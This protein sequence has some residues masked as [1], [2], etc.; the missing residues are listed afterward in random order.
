[1]KSFQFRIA[2]VAFGA[3]AVLAACHGGSLPFA[4][5]SQSG[6]VQY[7]LAPKNL[8]RSSAKSI[9]PC[10][11]YSALPGN[12]TAFFAVGTV[13]GTAFTGVVSKS[14]WYEFSFTKAAA[15]P[16]PYPTPSPAVAEFVYYGTYSLTKHHSKGCVYFTT[17]T[18]GRKLPNQS[19]NGSAFGTPYF[20]TPFSQG[21]KTL[22][23]GFVSSSFSKLSSSGGSGKLTLTDEYGKPFDTGTVDL[24]GR[25]L[26]V[27]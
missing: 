19:Y 23:Y 25:V 6:T 27:P 20:K 5:P 22:A 17:T 10:T 16:P 2:L 15:S 1:M 3:A 4:S 7:G 8:G 26:L 9:P 12:Y 13:Q 18:N 14:P 24:Q 11:N 21:S